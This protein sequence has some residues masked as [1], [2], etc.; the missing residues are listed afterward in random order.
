MMRWASLLSL[1][2]LAFSFQGYG[3]KIKDGNTAFER[4]QYHTAIPLL[5]KAYEKAPTRLEK[6]KSRLNWRKAT[7][8]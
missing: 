8:F 4:K 3:Q 6:G 1:L 7:G 5:S 2:L